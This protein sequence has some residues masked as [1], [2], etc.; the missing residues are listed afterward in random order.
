[1]DVNGGAKAGKEPE[2]EMA[3]AECLDLSAVGHGQREE[4]K[5][6]IE[7]QNFTIQHDKQLANSDTKYIG[8]HKGKG[9]DNLI[10]QDDLKRSHMPFDPLG[11]PDKLKLYSSFYGSTNSK[12]GLVKP[13]PSYND[14]HGAFSVFKTSSTQSKVPF[15]PTKRNRLERDFNRFDKVNGYEKSVNSAAFSWKVPTYDLK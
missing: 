13:A 10:D 12:H 3:I 6:K 5:E 2:N 9:I 11:K 8:T 7:R 1:M 14:A 4:F 15:S